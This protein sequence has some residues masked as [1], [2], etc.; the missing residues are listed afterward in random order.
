M[1]EYLKS[2]F[3]DIEL[4]QEYNLDTSKLWVYYKGNKTDITVD[5]TSDNLIKI[6]ESLNYGK[7]VYNKIKIQNVFKTLIPEYFL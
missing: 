4:I 7:S 1:Q 6:Y 5:T 2:A 3:G